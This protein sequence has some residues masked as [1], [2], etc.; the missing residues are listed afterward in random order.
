[1]VSMAKEELLSSLEN[2]KSALS[3]YG[4]PTQEINRYIE[5][6][7]SRADDKHVDQYNELVSAYRNSKSKQAVINS[8]QAILEYVRANPDLKQ[9]PRVERDMERIQDSVNFNHKLSQLV[10]QYN[11]AVTVE[12]AKAILNA[13]EQLSNEYNV[14]L[15]FIANAK[16]QLDAYIGTKV[17]NQ[18]NDYVDQFNNSMTPDRRAP[19]AQEIQSFLSANPKLKET[20]SG[21][22]LY[23]ATMQY[24]EFIQRVNVSINK[25]ESALNE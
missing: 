14:S 7:S 15:D 5:Q 11:S 17:V 25:I 20:D 3:M 2:L 19:L 4:I 13:I 12:E 1:M 22:S 10:D 21:I 23:H 9:L 24:L 18:F 16:K 8:G 6:V